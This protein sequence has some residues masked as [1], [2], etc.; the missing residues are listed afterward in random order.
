[1]TEYQI[2]LHRHW[3][4]VLAMPRANQKSLEPDYND[5]GLDMLEGV[6]QREL[7]LREFLRGKSA[8]TR[9]KLEGV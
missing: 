2:H 3:S 4:Q 5:F 9:K 7:A 1:M 8:A 6:K